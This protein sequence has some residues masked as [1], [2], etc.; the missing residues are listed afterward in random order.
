MDTLHLERNKIKEITSVNNSQIKRVTSLQNKKYRDAYKEFFIEGEKSIKEAIKFNQ[1]IKNIYYC[2][3]MIDYKF[4]FPGTEVTEEIIKKISDV[5]TSQ[6]IIA[7]CK[8]P[9]YADFKKDRILFLDRVQDPGNVGT[10]IRT[11]DA[12]G[13]NAVFLSKGCA[14]VYSPKVI[15]ATMGSI[16]HI[17]VIQNVDIEE[18]KAIGNKIFSSSLETNE[19]L[20]KIEISRKFTLVIGNE[21]N[22][23]SEEVK[24]ITNKFVKIKMNGNA[25]SLNA[26]IAAGILMYEFSKKI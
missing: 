2:P 1:K 7:V 23:I 25:E 8:T 20:D 24:N 6:G 10:I 12:F 9:Q 18:I 17:P 19:L 11:A 15:R 21:G 4:D 26:S 3:K 13:F 22:G 16:F 14:D 5:T